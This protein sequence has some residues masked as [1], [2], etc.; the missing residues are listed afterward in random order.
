MPPDNSKALTHRQI[1]GIL[2][3]DVPLRERVL[4]HLLYETAPRRC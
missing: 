1:A 2:A 4:W 3:L